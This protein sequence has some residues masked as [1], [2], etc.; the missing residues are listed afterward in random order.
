MAATALAPHPRPSS[1]APVANARPTHWDALDGLRGVAV[2]MV[3]CWHVFRFSVARNMS[4]HAVPPVFW[5]LGSLR[6][7]VDLFFV[8]SGLLIIRSWRLARE[9]QPSRLRALGHF[10]SRRARRILPAYWVMLAILIP[11]ASVN[12]VG[13][14]NRILAFVTLNQYVKFWL[15]DRVNTVTWS[16]TTEWHFYILVPVIAWVM[17]RFGRWPTLAACYGLSL[18]WWFH[19]PFKLP[20]SFVF[21]RLDQFVLGAIVGELVF[22]QR[23]HPI[24][25]AL[26]GRLVLP[27]AVLGFVALGSY[28][29]SSLG[30]GTD[31]TFD[32]FLH[33]L[34]GVCIAVALVHVL[35]RPDAAPVLTDSRLRWFGTISFGLYLWHY[36]ILDHG[37]RWARDAT[38]LPTAVSTTLAVPVLVAASVGVAFV[39]YTLVERRFL[40][41]RTPAGDGT[42]RR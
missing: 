42:P 18:W 9:H 26:R 5:P 15:P 14:P 30:M 23:D 6:L 33:P 27:A 19:L 12:I 35:S 16:L 37:L 21:G 38:S 10:W 41:R 20:S 28:H 11:F 25:R 39:S 8:L 1:P 2:L 24:V 22:E 17:L 3:V 36:P 7:G 32:A 29:G 13:R 4:T 31:R 40:V 34:I